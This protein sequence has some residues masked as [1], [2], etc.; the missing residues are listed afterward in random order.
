MLIAYTHIGADT[1]R[2]SAVFIAACISSLTG[3]NGTQVDAWAAIVVTVTILCA[4]IPLVIEIV[5]A[6]K[7][8]WAENELWP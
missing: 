7:T 5:K 8:L 6:F 3:I 1:L 2:T 4:V